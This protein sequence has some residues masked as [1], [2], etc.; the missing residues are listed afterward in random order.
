MEY[1]RTEPEKLSGNTFKMI[2][3]DWMLVTAEADGKVNTM[4]A[5]WGGVGV[6]WGRPVAY[7]FI[8]PQRY[9]YEFVEA[10]DR[11]TLTF[12]GGREREAL[13][14]CGTL[15][16]RDCDKIAKAGLV[17]VRLG[18]G[19]TS[20]EGADAV[21][22]CKKIYTDLIKPECMLDKSIDANYAKGD[23]HRMYVVEITD[24]Y[25]K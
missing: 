10:S 16:G 3:S 11:L 12:F 17:P 13:K 22:C 4:T 7:V 24:V 5:S 6:L 23:Y 9:T 14:L 20:F 19:L 15:S 21:L 2:G 8:R 18:E 1:R 25:T